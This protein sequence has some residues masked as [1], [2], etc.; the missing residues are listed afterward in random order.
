MEKRTETIAGI[1][2][3]L[4]EAGSAQ[5]QEMEDRYGKDERAGVQK[6]LEAYRYSRERMKPHEGR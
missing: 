5:R 4:L 3:R 2:A 1:R 6:L